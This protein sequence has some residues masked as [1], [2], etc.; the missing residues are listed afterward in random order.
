M[1]DNEREKTTAELAA[2]RVRQKQKAEEESQLKLQSQRDDQN[3]LKAVTE[4]QE[5]GCKDGGNVKLGK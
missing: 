2:W 1:K 3:N 4:K 5:N